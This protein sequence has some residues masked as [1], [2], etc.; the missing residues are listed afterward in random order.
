M[1][2][3][4][5]SFCQ[6]CIHLVDATITQRVLSSLIF[7]ASSSNP[8]S[9]TQQDSA[10]DVVAHQGDEVV[11]S[12]VAAV[13]VVASKLL[14]LCLASLHGCVSLCQSLVSL[15]SYFYIKGEKK[16][17]ARH[18][19]RLALIRSQNGTLQNCRLNSTALCLC[20]HELV[21]TPCLFGPI[22]STFRFAYR[23]CLKR[24]I[25]ITRFR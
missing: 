3:P 5:R 23:N 4:C 10:A 19:A 21:T 6:S 13:D 16:T 2:C 9:F 11:H 8:S 1:F 22:Q 14:S 20:A 18:I 17:L 7:F 25:D 24:L 12:V 15:L